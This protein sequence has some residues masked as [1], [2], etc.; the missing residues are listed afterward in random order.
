MVEMEQQTNDTP[1]SEAAIALETAFAPN[2][3]GT[4]LLTPIASVRIVPVS[5][6]NAFRSFVGN[7]AV[8]ETFTIN[9][10]LT[11]TELIANRRD[12]SGAPEDGIYLLSAPIADLRL[13]LSLLTRSVPGICA[14]LQA[15][16]GAELTVPDGMTA[17]AFLNTRLFILPKRDGDRLMKSELVPLVQ[18]GTVRPGIL[19]LTDTSGQ[20]AFR[21]A[22]EILKQEPLELTVSGSEEETFHDGFQSALAYSCSSFSQGS[23]YVNLASDL[24]YSGMLAGALGMFD[25]MLFYRLRQPPMRFLGNGKTALVVPRPS[26]ESGD[27]LYAFRPK[28]DQK[29]RPLIGEINRLRMLLE[30]GVQ[31][32]KIKSV[33]PLKKN[34][35]DMMRR[36]CGEELVYL[37]DQPFPEI[38]FPEM[39]FAVLAV[40][41]F[42]EQA[43]GTRLGSFQSK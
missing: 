10:L 24:P 29:N 40:L 5:V 11:A 7:V 43:P 35:M 42:G 1:K 4:K 18:V 19:R 17:N 2:G 16:G 20:S 38:R 22:E 27:V 26:V 3:W 28:C 8:G 33:L 25:A 36:I 21:S 34:A 39:P 37:P 32:G 15:C 31:E 6:A 41:R 9:E 23:Y 14:L 30:N 12:V 13:R